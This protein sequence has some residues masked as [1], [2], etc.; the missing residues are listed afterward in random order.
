VGLFLSSDIPARQRSLALHRTR[1][2]ERR[3]TATWAISTLDRMAATLTDVV[4]AQPFRLTSM[5]R[6]TL[7]DQPVLRIQLT[8]GQEDLQPVGINS[9]QY[10]QPG[11][12]QPRDWRTCV[13]FKHASVGEV[14]T[15]VDRQGLVLAG[16]PYVSCSE[17]DDAG[18]IHA[19]LGLPVERAGTADG[20]VTP[21]VLPGGDVALIMYTGL[22]SGI[23]VAY[24]RLWDEMQRAG[25]S[26]TLAPRELLM[27]NPEWDP[28]PEHNW[29]HLVWPVVA[30]G[31][32]QR[33]LATVSRAPVVS[34]MV[35]P[36]TAAMI[37]TNHSSGRY[38][39]SSTA[40]TTRPTP[41]TTR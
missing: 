29:A 4:A 23:G 10:E 9:P 41:M 39:A 7:W 17:P 26:P 38:S 8:L 14:Q 3:D 25:L 40:P 34:S 31:R 2:V 15:V 32:V 16:P 5:V 11:Q 30:T 21:G 19:E 22:P 27:T 33:S 24:Q 35:A 28:N 36:P 12:D 6:Q 1:L 20:R 13:V 37:V 18:T